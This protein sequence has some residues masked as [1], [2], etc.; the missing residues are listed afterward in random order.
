MLDMSKAFDKVN[1]KTVVEFLSEVLDQYELHIMKVLTEDVKLQDKIEAIERKWLQT[2]GCHNM[3]ACP[4][5]SSSF[6]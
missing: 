5:S 6:I 2:Q 3:T 1:W 4:H